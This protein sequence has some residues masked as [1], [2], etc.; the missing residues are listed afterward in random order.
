MA[1]VTNISVNDTW[2]F[3]FNRLDQFE[4][5]FCTFIYD[6]VDVTKTGLIRINTL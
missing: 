2:H 4:W 3:T 1:E 5:S 6:S